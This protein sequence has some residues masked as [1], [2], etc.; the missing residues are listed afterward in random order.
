MLHRDALN[1]TTLLWDVKVDGH[2]EGAR[3]EVGLKE[4]IER[5]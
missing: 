3:K 2:K 1:M 4:G 5:K